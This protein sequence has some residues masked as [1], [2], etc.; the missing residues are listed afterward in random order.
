MISKSMISDHYHKNYK[1]LDFDWFK[2]LLFSTYLLAKLSSDSLLPG[3][4]ISQ[5]HSKLQFK[6]TSH[7]LGFNHHRNSVQTPKLG[8]DI[9]LPFF[10]VTFNNLRLLYESSNTNFPLLP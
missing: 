3:S 7:N 2:K 10:R 4:F 8:L 6:S 5:S 9:F 1:F